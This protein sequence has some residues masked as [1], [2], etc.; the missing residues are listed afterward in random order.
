VDQARSDEAG[1]SNYETTEAKRLLWW[2]LIDLDLRLSLLVNRKP[3]LH[4]GAF[5]F[6]QPSFD[7]LKPAE[8]LLQQRKLEFKLLMMEVLTSINADKAQATQVTEGRRP[9]QES[10]LRKFERLQ[11]KVLA[12][13]QDSSKDIGHSI[14][15]AEHQLDVHLFSIMFYSH[16][17][18]FTKSDQFELPGPEKSSAGQSKPVKSRTLRKKSSDKTQEVIFQSARTV[19]ELFD[20]LFISDS[21]RTALSWT[22]CFGAY[23]AAV[24]LGEARLRQDV[25]PPTDSLRIQQTLKVFQELSATVPALNIARLASASLESLAVALGGL[26]RGRN[27]PVKTE[28]MQ[29]K[30]SPTISRE[31]DASLGSTQTKG[32]SKVDPVATSIQRQGKRSNPSVHDDTQHREKRPKFSTNV[33]SY[34][35]RRQ[36]VP[37][38]SS[39][40]EHQYVQQGSSISDIPMEPFH[41]QSASTSFTGNEPMEYGSYGSNQ[42]N[43]HHFPVEPWYHPPMFIHPPMYDRHWWGQGAP[44]IMLGDDGIQHGFYCDS[45]PMTMNAQHH[46]DPQLHDQQSMILNT[47]AHVNAPHVVDGSLKDNTTIAGPTHTSIGPDQVQPQH[48]PTFYNAVE[49]AQ[50]P[51]G[52]HSISSPV[53]GKA[54]TSR[55]GAF[56]HP[57]DSTRRHSVADIRQPRAWTVETPANYKDGKKQQGKVKASI[58]QP[59]T[60]PRDGILSPLSEAGLRSRRNSTTPRQIAEQGMN[61]DFSLEDIHP[62]MVLPGHFVHTEEYPGSRRASL[63]PGLDMSMTDANA[64]IAPGAQVS[65]IAEQAAA[66]WQQG[67]TRGAASVSQPH[68]DTIR[69]TSYD[70]Y[71]LDMTPYNAAPQ[72]HLFPHQQRQQSLHHPHHHY[73]A[74]H[75]FTGPLRQIATTGP[76]EPGRWRT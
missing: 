3:H 35:G 64:N 15:V 20:F 39:S 43:S 6:P 41:D 21:T 4:A 34:D 14:A 42:D 47:M 71:D 67:Q 25:D 36:S 51:A 45:S 60:S 56:A 7:Y 53:L 16:L 33:P 72:F 31:P 63:A 12:L 69:A 70:T 38:W 22:Q 27:A 65:A 50:Y 49:E 52:Q 62:P 10:V 1:T 61:L 40:Q 18:R 37:D 30:R 74:H 19:M 66:T 2:H 75:D 23:S 55:E 5:E 8:K 44:P 59:R 26:V 57:A 73:P 32:K 13:S 54:P 68:F 46:L 58:E 11:E 17:A 48:D 28:P 24:L 29:M 9:E 76:F